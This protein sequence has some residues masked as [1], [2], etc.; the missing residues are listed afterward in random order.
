ML[1]RTASILALALGLAMPAA[2]QVTTKRAVSD[3]DAT[4]GDDI[5]VTGEKTN[6]TLQETPASVGVTTREAISN[7]NLV[8]VYDVLERT[9][10]VSVMGNR[11]TFSLRGIDAFSVSGGGDGAL[12]SVYVDGAVL[13]SAALAVGPLDL[14]DIAQVEVF[15]GPQST[16]QGRN[17][18]AG[19]V[20]IRT[21]DPSYTWTGRARLLM[22]DQ[23][24]QRRAAAAIGGPI[25]DGQV[26]FRIAGEI[27]RADGLVRN[28]TLN[29]D[30]DE[31]RS[32][33]IRGKLLLTPKAIPGLR[34][35]GTF[36]HDHHRRGAYFTEL[37]P[38]YRP[39][40]RITAE[41]VQDF[42]NVNSDIATLEAGYD[43]AQ[44][45]TLSS[46]TN[47][48][49]IKS[50]GLFDPDRSAVT[51]ANSS[52]SDPTKTFQ[53]EFR[54]NIDRS[55]VKGVIGGYYLREDNRDYFFA[56]N[57][58]LGLRRLGIDIAL[59]NLGLP[60]ATV[61]AVLNQYGGAV[62]IRNSLMQ[63]RLT[64]NYAGF[65]DLTFPVTSRLRITAGLRYDSES[66]DRGATQRVDITEPLPNPAN[67]PAGLAPI[68]TLLNAQLV[69][70]AAGASSAEPIRK[71]TYHAWLPKAGITYDLAEDLSLS[72]T[73]QRGYRAG[74]AGINQQRAQ[75]YQYNPEYTWNYE[76]ALRSEFFDR[77][78]TVNANAF[79]IDWRDQ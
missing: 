39:E 63:P 68:V 64:H 71:V 78:L 36:L 22:T 10:N 31:R 2:A 1:F 19:A 21:T 4:R 56:A 45:L 59:A 61:D 69:S 24:G 13:P 76:L 62:T 11:N 18:I 9:P 38:P 58:R 79:Y 42:T 60:P 49:D 43:L 46:V 67:V 66:Q 54:L 53:Q 51:G 30:G 5:V 57:Q 37:E 15:R 73:A 44:G 29:Q 34:I 32:E 35:V 41:D 8:S 17:A 6:R 72:F 52:I 50:F 27:A 7:Q 65:A 20:I 12:A 25:I 55:W 14:Y 74:G 28:V 70:I 40:Q 33:T 48:S 75:Y 26:A 47:Y 16:V 77:R 23:D 3:D